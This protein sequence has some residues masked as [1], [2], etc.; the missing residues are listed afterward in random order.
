VVGQV[1]QILGDIGINIGG[2]QVARSERKDTALV[3]L[4]VDT[5]LPQVVAAK[6]ADT[7]GAAT[8]SVVNL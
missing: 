4:N 6:I 3:I 7:V 8:F 1:G 2:M 5:E